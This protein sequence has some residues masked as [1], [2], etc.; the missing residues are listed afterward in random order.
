MNN[1][2][3]VSGW[4]FNPADFPDYAV[5]DDGGRGWVNKCI[6]YGLAHGGRIH[7]VG[8]TCNVPNRLASYERG[9]EQRT[10]NQWIKDI[11]FKNIHMVCLYKD[12]GT[13][14]YPDGQNDFINAHENYLISQHG[15][16]MYND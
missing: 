5:I 10:V 9:H 8:K 6:V 3:H 14:N 2:Q 15:N 4:P 13:P 1:F 12:D 11:G 16:V 7:Y